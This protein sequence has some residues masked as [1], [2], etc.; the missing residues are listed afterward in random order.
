MKYKITIRKEID[1]P[2]YDAEVAKA[3]A[4]QSIYNQKYDDSFKTNKFIDVDALVVDLTEEEFKQI[5][6]AVLEVM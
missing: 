6:K 1:N 2:D 5:K 3:Y 4:K